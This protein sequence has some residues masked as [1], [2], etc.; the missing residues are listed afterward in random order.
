MVRRAVSALDC[1]NSLSIINDPPQSY[2]VDDVHTVLDFDHHVENVTSLVK[3]TEP[4]TRLADIT[5]K[6]GTSGTPINLVSDLKELQ[7]YICSSTALTTTL[8]C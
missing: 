2:Y 8:R 4:H 6:R 1:L 5:D 3:N 7:T